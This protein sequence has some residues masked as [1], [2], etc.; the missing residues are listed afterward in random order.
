M[1]QQQLLWQKATQEDVM[2]REAAAQKEKEAR[3]KLV[4]RSACPHLCVC[5][6]PSIQ[7]SPWQHS[8]FDVY[9]CR[10]CLLRHLSA[11]QSRV[12]LIAC[13]ACL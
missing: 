9:K 5:S 3:K 7:P 6:S 2:R 11:K 12:M 8:R 4:S 13:L 1:A 10:C